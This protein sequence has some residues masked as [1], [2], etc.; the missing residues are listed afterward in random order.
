MI[1]A[2]ETFLRLWELESLTALLP[3]SRRFQTGS[4]V[5]AASRFVC[6]HLH[7]KLLFRA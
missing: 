7:Q 5:V 6:E 4:I 1:N 2:A 3:Q